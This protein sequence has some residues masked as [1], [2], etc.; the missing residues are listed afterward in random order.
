MSNKTKIFIVIAIIFLAAGSR[1]V[2]HP[3]NFTP[4]AAMAIFAG[5]YFKKKWGLAFPLAAMFISD[6]FIGFYDW[7]IMAAVY[8]SMGSAYFIGRLL[9]KRTKW[10]NVVFASLSSS[11]AFFFITNLAV[12]LFGNWY[13]H[14]FSGLANCFVL[15]LPFFRNTL[16]GDLFYTGALFG[17][18]G[19]V[20]ALAMKRVVQQVIA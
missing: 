9:A 10:Q 12:W 15:A 16:A 6:Y 7:R 1:L 3:Y 13:P 20:V 11:L 5:C 8:L 14:N 17:A 19:L 18:Y 4:I 2:K